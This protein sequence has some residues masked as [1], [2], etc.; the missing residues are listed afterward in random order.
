[1]I[2][3]LIVYPDARIKNISANVRSFG[4]SLTSII[5]DMKE[6]MIDLNI[7]ALSAMQIGIQESVILIRE[8]DEFK[9]FINLRIIGTEGSISQSESSLY[10]GDLSVDIS[11]A[12]LIKVIYDDENGA[13]QHLNCSGDFSRVLQVQSDYTFGSTFMDRVGPKGRQNIEN[14][15]EYGFIDGDGGSCPTV[16]VRDY[17]SRAINYVLSAILITL[18][19]SFFFSDEE[20]LRTLYKIDLYSLGLVGLLIA[21]YFF[22]AQYEIRKFSTCSSCQTGNIFANSIVYITE[23]LFVGVLTYFFMS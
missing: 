20:T 17:I 23:L 22:Y 5:E 18:P 12:D 1:M 16:F 9:A 21:S 11:R 3:E 15:L 4:E 14:Q 10:Y 7:N 19:I 6:T 2:R 13:Q 8:K